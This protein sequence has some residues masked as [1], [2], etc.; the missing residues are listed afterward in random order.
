[1]RRFFRNRTV[2]SLVIIF[3][4]IFF[5]APFALPGQSEI[6]TAIILG[7]VWFWCLYAPLSLPL[8][9]LFF[10]GLIAELFRS[11]PP[12]ILL[13][14]MLATYGVAHGW[15]FKLAQGR[16]LA[17][18][19]AFSLTMIGG[20]ILE[21]MLMSLRAGTLLSPLVALFQFALTVGIYPCLYVI[22]IWE[23]R[24]FNSDKDL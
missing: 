18:W 6:Q 17:S 21:W 23:R 22:F 10:S 4:A 12:G 3:T 8:L 2:P 13:L 20:V 19:G 1:M 15:R 16:F 5:S 11:G 14:W 7:T 9:F 24:I